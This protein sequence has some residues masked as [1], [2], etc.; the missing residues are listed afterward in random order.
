MAISFALTL[1]VGLCMVFL[2]LND[3]SDKLEFL[4]NNDCSEDSI[5]NNSFV[6]MYVYIE[7]LFYNNVITCIVFLFILF[8]QLFFG[9]LHFYKKATKTSRMK[10]KLQEIAMT[11][12]LI[13]NQF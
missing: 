2:F 8:T 10:K 11:D 7:G 9:M 1:L 13:K 5:M 12:Y 6:T 3:S 4:S